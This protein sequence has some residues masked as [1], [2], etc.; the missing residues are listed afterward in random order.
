MARK[1]KNRYNNVVMLQ[2][3]DYIDAQQEWLSLPEGKLSV[4]VIERADHIVV[5]SAIAG[6][7]AQ[8]LEITLSD[9]T[10]TV[11]GQRA[12]H[13]EES[14]GDQLHVQECHWGAFSRTILLP[15]H[16]DPDHV[17]A[18]LKRGILTITAKKVEMEKI[19]PILE[20]DDL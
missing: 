16:V 9:D 5:R 17:E 3:H 12:H 2:A 4:D 18:T 14:R 7:R 10:L 20:I 1:V 8:D 13:C 19:V 6:V 15:C 11:R